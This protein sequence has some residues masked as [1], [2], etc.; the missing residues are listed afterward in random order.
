MTRLICIALLPLFLVG[1]VPDVP[2]KTRAMKIESDAL[3]AYCPEPGQSVI[4]SFKGS[5]STIF[6][7]CNASGEALQWRESFKVAAEARGWKIKT[8]GTGD[9]YCFGETGI[10]LG[11]APTYDDSIEGR[12][13]L[14]FQYPSSSCGS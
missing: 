14:I 2:I 6:I 8:R 13:A 7:K 4:Y 5:I 3:K 11:V 12:R 10:S 1:C 9:T